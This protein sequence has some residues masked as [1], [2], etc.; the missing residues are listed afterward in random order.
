[1]CM[2]ACVHRN[3]KRVSDPLELESQVDACQ[4]AGVQEL[5]SGPEQNIILPAEPSLWLLY[6]FKIKEI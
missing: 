4:P 1:M 2:S 6:S 3:Q 5:N